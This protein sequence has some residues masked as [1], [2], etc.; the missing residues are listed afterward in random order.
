M[1][2]T[3]ASA[4]SAS[5]DLLPGCPTLQ[6]P[7]GTIDRADANL[8]RM[9]DLLA[10]SDNLPFDLHLKYIER[11]AAVQEKLLGIRKAIYQLDCAA[12]NR[13]TA[14]QPPSPSA[15]DQVANIIAA[16]EAVAVV[17]PAAPAASPA[18]PD[19]PDSPDQSR[20]PNES[21]S[22]NQTPNFHDRLASIPEIPPLAPLSSGFAR[23][24]LETSSTTT[25]SSAMATPAVTATPATLATPATPACS[26]NQILDQLS[27]AI[28]GIDQ[29]SSELHCNLEK[30]APAA[31]QITTSNDAPASTIAHQSSTPTGNH[32]MPCANPSAPSLISDA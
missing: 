15:A 18:A 10:D 9:M 5:A 12:A 14:N 27:Q 7:A 24:K 30:A 16:I 2:S 23:P 28:A 17:D 29:L 26:V 11:I 22:L 25:I 31:E 6:V 4:N 32:T 19:S 1:S 20:S 8:Y 13:Q 21:R 3:S